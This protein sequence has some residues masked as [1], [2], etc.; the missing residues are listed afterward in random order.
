M[1]LDTLWQDPLLYGAYLAII[2]F[3]ICL[4]ELC[5]AWAAAWQG[6]ETAKQLGYFTLNPMVHMGPA[7]LV[8]LALFGMAWGLCPVNPARFRGRYSDAI[9]SF[10]GPFANLMLMLFCCAA[11]LVL[12]VSG[13]GADWLWVLNLAALINTY[14][15]LFNLIPLP[16]LDG[17]P[18]LASL[19]P[20][21]RPLGQVLQPYGFVLLIVLFWLGL[22]KIFSGLSREVVQAVVLTMADGLGLRAG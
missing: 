10:A 6:D 12:M 7:S 5:H 11:I 4:H 9:V 17:F 19:V 3:S 18:I 16:P 2:I 13:I 1:F 22:G 21:F 15:F 14:L 8:L 20:P